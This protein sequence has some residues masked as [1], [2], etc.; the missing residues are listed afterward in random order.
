MAD[1][2]LPEC[3]DI[4]STQLMRIGGT[5]FMEQFWDHQ[6]FALRQ[7]AVAP[8]GQARDMTD[9]STELATRTGL[10][11]AYNQAINRGILGVPLVGNG[12]SFQLDLEK[13]YAAAVI[14][15]RVCRAASA[16]VTE[17][18]ESDGLDWYREHGYRTRP[19]SR[20]TWYL[21]PELRRQNIRFE[22][23]YQE[24][25]LRVGIELG[26]R[27]HEQ[28]IE[29]WNAQL[30]EY[31]AFPTCK[32]F[33]GIWE[34]DLARHGGKLADYPFWLLTSRSMQYSWGANAGIPLMKEVSANLRGHGGVVI[35]ATRARE[36]GIDDGD[37]VEIR[38]YLRS[39]YGR[40]TLS[41]GIRP[42]CLLM[43]GQFGHWVM[44]Y[45]KDMN[46][47]NMNTV[48]P[49]SI[50]L[51]DATGSGTDLVR[52]SIAKAENMSRVRSKN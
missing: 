4:E 27:L 2:L 38:S 42:D 35:N 39:T 32:D 23:P 31:E 22:M 20:L 37:T 36:L 50:E 49:M 48:T 12:H 33:P 28:G 47:P 40:A 11:E 25:L 43:I 26:N 6:G 21:F 13:K 34:K 24:R 17:G 16:E 1:V 29:W 5:K 19:I 41:E 15:D 9:I 30:S 3:T 46:A 52:A 7:S 44:P 18:R 51:T 8:P 45:A 10:L 14:W